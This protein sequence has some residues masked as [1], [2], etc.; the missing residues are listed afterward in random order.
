M[1][2]Y[3]LF[4]YV[5]Q[6]MDIKNRIKVLMLIFTVSAF[7][8]VN[9]SR[10]HSKTL[11]VIRISF[12]LLW[13]LIASGSLCLI[14]GSLSLPVSSFSGLNTF[15]SAANTLWK[16]VRLL[17]IFLCKKYVLLYYWLHLPLINIVVLISCDR[18]YNHSFF[19]F[20]II[21]IKCT[22][23]FSFCQNCLKYCHSVL[24]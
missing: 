13:H 20:S 3:N 7:T 18:G 19:S 15:L 8:T 5:G 4:K 24:S 11:S 1:W 14:Y 2:R 16:W 9:K 17:M 12:S 10:T 6:I 22:Q 21:F 23:C